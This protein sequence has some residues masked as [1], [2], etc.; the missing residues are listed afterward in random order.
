MCD[1]RVRLSRHAPVTT[2]MD[3]MLRRR[4]SSRSSFENACACL[5]DDAAE[6]PPRSVALGRGARLDAG[7]DR[8]GERAAGACDLIATP[9]LDGVNPPA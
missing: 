8:G 3:D 7:S 1:E 6:R 5:T 4:T 9:K 2:A